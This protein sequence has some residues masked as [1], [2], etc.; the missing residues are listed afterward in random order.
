MLLRTLFT[1]YDPD[2]IQLFRAGK[3]SKKFFVTS[4]FPFRA[5]VSSISPTRLGVE[6]VTLVHAGPSPRLSGHPPLLLGQRPISGGVELR[7]REC[8]N[9]FF[10]LFFTAAGPP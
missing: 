9:V 5:T 3:I 7:A 8:L 10:R 4:I 1:F 6:M 2:L